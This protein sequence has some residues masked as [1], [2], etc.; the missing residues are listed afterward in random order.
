MNKDQ[1]DKLL[2][3]LS[4]EAKRIEEKTGFGICIIAGDGQYVLFSKSM[5]PEKIYDLYGGYAAA[6]ITLF[7]LLNLLSKDELEMI[8]VILDTILVRAAQHVQKEQKEAAH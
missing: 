8:R 1:M 2:D 7:Q 3:K 5:E 4:E 6:C